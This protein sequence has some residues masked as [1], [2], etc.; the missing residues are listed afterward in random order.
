MKDEKIVNESLEDAVMSVLN[1]LHPDDYPSENEVA[2][3]NYN[4]SVITVTNPSFDP[5]IIVGAMQG[6]FDCLGDDNFKIDGG[7]AFQMKVQGGDVGNGPD[8]IHERKGQEFESYVRDR[9]N[10]L[11]KVIPSLKTTKFN[12]QFSREE[13]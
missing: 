7:T 10:I 5:K 12:V 9:L 8:D 6:V 4:T 3:Q 2:E 11:V 13:Y 1:E